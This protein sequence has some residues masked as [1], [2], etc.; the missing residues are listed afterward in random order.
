[1]EI[2]RDQQCVTQTD[3]VRRSCSVSSRNG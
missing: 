1:M 3:K 2:F